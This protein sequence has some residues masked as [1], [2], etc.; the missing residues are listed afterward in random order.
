MIGGMWRREEGYIF[1]LERM[2]GAASTGTER[3]TSG[4][5]IKVDSG[6]GISSIEE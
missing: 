5:W 4:G 1:V 6:G 3:S 2:V